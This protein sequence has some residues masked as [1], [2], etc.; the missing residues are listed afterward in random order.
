MSLAESPS[1]FYVRWLDTGAPVRNTGQ[2]A[3]PHLYLSAGKA[4]AQHYGTLT[5]GTTELV[6]VK[7]VEIKKEPS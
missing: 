1:Y 7:L 2:S 3:A 4:R 5:R 6:E